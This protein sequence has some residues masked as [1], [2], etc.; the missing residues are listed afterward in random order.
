[1]AIVCIIRLMSANEILNKVLP[2]LSIAM[3][4]VL[5]VFILVNMLIGMGRGAKRAGIRFVIYIG[6]LIVAFLITPFVVNWVLEINF[7]IAGK[8]PAEHVENVSN[9]FIEVLQEQFGDYVVPFQDYIK[10]Y[11]LG[12]VVALLNLLIFFALYFVVK[13]VAW[14][15]YVIVA[16]FAAPKR[17]REG[18]KYPKYAGWGML[19]GAVQ[20]LFLFVIF[21]LPVNG[22]VGMINQAANYQGLQTESHITTQN[23]GGMG[24]TGGA[25]GIGGNPY[26][27]TGMTGY[28]F[29]NINFDIKFEDIDINDACKKLDKSLATYNNVMK[30]T[31][32]QFISNKA[33]EYQLTVRVKGAEKINLVHDINSG[34]E[35]Y[36][37]SKAF[38]Q[39]VSK[40]QG[41]VN[42]GK[43]DLTVLD[44]EDYEVLRQVVN[45]AFDLEILQVAN[46]LLADLDKIFS[47][48]FGEDLTYLDGTEIYEHSIYGLLV[49]NAT[50]DRTFTYGPGEGNPT[51][52]KQFGDGLHSLINYVADQKLNL[53]RND[54]LNV[55]DMVQAV[56]DYQVT[57]AGLPQPK[58]LAKLLAQ[59]NLKVENYL[60]FASA[61]LVENC[62]EYAAGTPII[63]VLGHRLLQFSL[64][65]MIGLQDFNHLVTYS[66]LMDHQFDGNQDLKT[67]VNDMIPLFLGEKALTH[68]GQKGNWEK[69]GDT[70]F[71]V[72][73]VLR[74]YVTIADDINANKEQLISEDASL[75]TPGQEANLQAK[76]LLKYL[77]DLVIT[78]D[79]YNNH[80]SEFPGLTYGKTVKYQK[81]DALVDALYEIVNEFAPV[82]TFLVSQLDK[83]Q[84]SGEFST[85]MQTLI[86]MFDQEKETWK[87][88]LENIVNMAHVINESSL[89]DLINNFEDPSSVNPEDF[90]NVIN[91]MNSNDVADLLTNI[92]DVPEVGNAVQDALDGILGEIDENDLTDYFTTNGVDVADPVISSQ[93]SEIQSDIGTLQSALADY[94]NN[95]SE[96]NE[97]ALKSAIGNLWDLFQGVLSQGTGA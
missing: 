4:G 19:I 18:K 73:Q 83:M 16:H 67:F 3:L 1:M 88:T 39:V 6:L 9:Q 12:V 59:D 96:T 43:V 60:D 14:G 31:G 30:C 63:K 92:I 97:A 17:D 47:T 56:G 11:A 70:L 23:M 66:K 45:K 20:G 52:Y 46:Q 28:D 21:L 25:G 94:N 10:E 79:Y 90:L 34:W 49:K 57:Y 27:F 72:A 44:T 36:R 38:M 77:S 32:L 64:V 5:A 29:S 13:V 7:A 33:F 26:D 69:L 53:I 37:D 41:M 71:D 54:I 15:V 76:A 82:K 50:T 87:S 95:S 55:I 78:E 58:T 84:D 42:G 22:V 48:P 89:G 68:D 91:E 61:K 24:G 81:V 51:N 35:L 93:I 40:L 8:T 65:K 86:D 62:D 75:A 85:Y 80:L 2:F 74:N